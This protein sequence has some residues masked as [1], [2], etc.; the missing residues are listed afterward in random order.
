MR[1]TLHH[2][3]V[4][5]FAVFTAAALALQWQAN[6]ELRGE[7][8]LLSGE[9]RQLH[10]LRLEHD[11]LVAAQPSPAMMESMRSD[12]AAVERLRGE[13]ELMRNRVKQMEGR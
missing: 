6:Q 10:Q 4:G 5:L 11:R 1:I 9:S 8:A 7:I 12:H 3:A 2:V 13:V